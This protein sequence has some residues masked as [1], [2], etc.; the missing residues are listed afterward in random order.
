MTDA[1]SEEQLAALPG[2]ITDLVDKAITAKTNVTSR[3]AGEVTQAAVAFRMM[4][5]AQQTRL[6]SNVEG[7]T[8]LVVLVLSSGS[9]C[10]GREESV[11]NGGGAAGTSYNRCWRVHSGW[12]VS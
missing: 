3:G 8:P 5:E 4:E 7:S 2:L 10:S 6:V 9:G 12:S 11:I 1:F